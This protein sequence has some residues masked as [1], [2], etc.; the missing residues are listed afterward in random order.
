MSDLIRGADL[1]ISD[2]LA[3]FQPLVE[4][5]IAQVNA[6]ANLNE[7]WVSEPI[8]AENAGE[9]LVT[10]MERETFKRFPRT[11]AILFTIR[12]HMKPLNNFEGK[13]DKV[14]LL[15]G[16]FTGF[17]R[18]NKP[19]LLASE[20][21]MTSGLIAGRPAGQ[22]AAQSTPR[23]CTVQD[24]CSF[25]GTG[26]GVS[27]PLCRWKAGTGGEDG[28]AGLRLRQRLSDLSVQLAPMTYRCSC[29]RLGGDV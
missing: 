19:Q 27:G 11:K 4:E 14:L 28:C 29:W 25:P 10:R 26:A 1:Q 9:R 12:T 22:C 5:D 24:D 23:D 2:N 18:L 13:P 3:K 6:G 21:I 16:C 20:L 17:L 8:T 15:A 7:K